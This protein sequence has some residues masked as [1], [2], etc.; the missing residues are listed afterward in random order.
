MPW[1]A[2]LLPDIL[3]VDL[4]CEV[5]HDNVKIGT[6]GLYVITLVKMRDLEQESGFLLLIIH[7]EKEYLGEVTRFGDCSARVNVMRSMF[8][9]KRKQIELKDDI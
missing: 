1:G 6:V 7:D 3:A 2:R 8:T 9:W 5:H 4:N